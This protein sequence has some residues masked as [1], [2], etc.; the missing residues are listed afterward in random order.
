MARRVAGRLRARRPHCRPAPDAHREVGICAAPRPPVRRH[1]ANGGRE[2][3]GHAVRRRPSRLGPARNGRRNCRAWP[4]RLLF[5]GHRGGCR[6][7]RRSCGTHLDR[8]TRG[9]KTAPVGRCRGLLP[10]QEPW[11]RARDGGRR[12]GSGERRGRG[13]SGAGAALQRGVGCRRS[14]L[15][16][17][18]ARGSDRRGGRRRLGHRCGCGR[19]RW[20]RR[21]VRAAG[22]DRLPLR[23]TSPPRRG[24][25]KL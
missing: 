3:A 17:R 2:D 1:R 23:G 10:D 25:S 13:Q 21:S 18:G 20:R 19:R 7:R 5:P 8:E 9:G 4:V 11:P 6:R 14:R 16:D 22:R 15:A 24:S 12:R